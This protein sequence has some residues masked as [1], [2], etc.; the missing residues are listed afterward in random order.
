MKLLTALLLIIVLLACASPVQAATFSP[1]LC[2]IGGWKLAI[3]FYDKHRAVST[4]RED[5]VRHWRE[6][7]RREP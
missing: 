5:V 7:P 2:W 3:E 1:F 4:T 6:R